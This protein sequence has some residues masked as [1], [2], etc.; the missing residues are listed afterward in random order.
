MNISGKINLTQ[1]KHKVL[2]LQG[3]NG[4]IDCV[5]LPIE[6][7]SF[8]KG[9]KGIYFDIA[10]YELKEKRENQTHLLKQSFPK[11]VFERMTEQ[12]KTSIPI[13][14]SMTV[15]GPREPEPV[16]VDIEMPAVITPELADGLPF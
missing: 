13:I 12:Q 4:L 2:K 9:E 14:G 7:N 11:E 10:A 3:K 6:A 16:K 5:V 8:I 1:L 15:W